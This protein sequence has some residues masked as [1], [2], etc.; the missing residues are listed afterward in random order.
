MILVG[1][2]ITFDGSLNRGFN[3]GC[4]DYASMDVLAVDAQTVDVCLVE[5][6]TCHSCWQVGHGQDH[7]HQ[8]TGEPGDVLRVDREDVVPEWD[9]TYQEYRWGIKQ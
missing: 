4:R 6:E 8:F 5:V 2:T 1:D 7:R 9:D 3:H